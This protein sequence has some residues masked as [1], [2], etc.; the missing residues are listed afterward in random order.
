MK[1]LE[2]RKQKDEELPAL[3]G[4][5]DELT[6]AGSGYGYGYGYGF[7]AHGKKIDLGEYWQAIR[8]RLWL[9]ASITA[10]ITLLVTVYVSQK[11]DYYMATTRVQVNLEN[12]PAL[13]DAKGGFV[14]QGVYDPSHFSSQLQIIEGS[15]LLR[16]VV[17][18]LD[19]QNNQAFLNPRASQN[20]SVWRNVVRMIGMGQSTN[21][22]Q[23]QASRDQITLTP[24][25]PSE[26]SAKVIDEKELERLAPYVGMLKSGLTVSAVKE[27]RVKNTETRLIDIRFTHYDPEV[28]TK[29]ANDIA[30][31]YVS[32]NYERKIE[33]NAT[34]GDFLQKRVTELQSQIRTNEERLMNYAKNNQILS[35][36]AGQNTVVQRLADLNSKLSQAEG[37]RIMA[38]AAYRASQRPGAATAQTDSD[39]RATALETRLS[40]LRNQRARLL[41]EYTDEAPE[42]VEL[43]KQI[44]LALQEIKETRSRATNT[45]T[46]NLETKYQEALARQQDLSR[47]FNQQRAEVLAQNQAAINYRIIQQDIETDK[48]LLN[49]LLQRSKENDVVLSGTPNNVLVVD[50]ALTPRA[51]VGPKRGQYVVLAFLLSLGLGIGL[52]LLLNYLDHT[53]RTVDDIESRLHL[54]VLS[55]VP[56][57]AKSKMMLQLT[58]FGSNKRESYSMAVLDLKHEPALTEAYLHLRTGVLLATAGGPP[59]ILLITSGQPSEGK[60]TTAINMATVLAQTGVRVLLIDADL[61]RPSLHTILGLNYNGHDP[62][63]GLSS[64]LTAKALDEETIVDS[65][66]FHEE[67]GLYVL[68][69]GPLPPNPANLI[70]SPQMEQLLG[71]LRS[72]FTHIVIDSPPVG[73]F[74]DGV[75]LSRL[76]DGVLL[77]VRSGKSPLEVAQRAKKLL[78]DAGASFFGV[79]LNDC[80]GPISK[81]YPYNYNRVAELP[82][83]D[84]SFLKLN[85]S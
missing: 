78:W 4:K 70:C 41:V 5:S 47:I 31:T 62:S 76:V 32:Q 8:K 54:P 25:I 51:P 43:N 84:P 16:R 46:T 20:N 79:V 39:G 11:P 10:V 60:T 26:P 37:D 68:T 75:L 35:L 22:S 36:D 33:N 67:S 24:T 12:N 19:L 74:T 64:L 59:E 58:T 52:A 49:G 23:P 69:S 28:A 44:A 72:K 2:A 81:Y 18:S 6:R 80:P 34:A 50:R 55:E 56:S 30:D 77:V 61:R 45:L 1:N 65:I 3:E 21:T 73:F 83:A 57:V 63:K 71:L 9:I 48:S 13:G 42:I 7:E 38:E 14:F 82:E 53:V 85:A 15:G 29:I 66:K 17:N 40:E 27:N